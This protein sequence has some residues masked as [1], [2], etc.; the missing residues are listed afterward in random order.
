MTR[1]GE[2]QKNQIAAGNNG[3]EAVES[4]QPE[5]AVV[6]D[7]KT[8]D[9]VSDNNA[10]IN[11]TVAP[12]QREDSA[13]VV[14]AA[15]HDERRRAPHLL[16]AKRQKSQPRRGVENA[17]APRELIATNSEPGW[18]VGRMNLRR[19]KNAPPPAPGLREFIAAHG[20]TDW[21]VEQPLTP[22]QRLAA[23]QLMLALRVASAKFNYAQREMQEIG[24]AGK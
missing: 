15:T 24:R 3:S 4:K 20:M 18:V 17:P 13:F 7:D 1:Q 19:S 5:K 14:K 6:T 8:G 9:K 21:Q 2:S 10:E 22:Q 12:K 11:N 23:E 16:M